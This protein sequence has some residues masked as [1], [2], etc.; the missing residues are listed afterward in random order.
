SRKDSPQDWPVA[1][2][3]GA[4][5]YGPPFPVDCLP[6]WMSAWVQAEAEATQTPPD[7]AALLP[8]SFAGAALAKKV[9]V[10]VREGWSE[11]TNIFTATALLSG[12][13]KS[14]VFEAALAPVRAFEAEEQQ[15][16]APLIA[17]Q[18]SERRTLEQRLQA[19]EKQASKIPG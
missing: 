11:P 4:E 7:L 13:R 19:L 6:R 12:E 5:A 16:M 1:I 18:A 17:E 2:P 10:E 8:L 14:A 15:R 9:R 3:F